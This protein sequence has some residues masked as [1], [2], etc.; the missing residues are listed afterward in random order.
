MPAQTLIEVDAH[1]SDRNP[2]AVK[3]LTSL[4]SVIPLACLGA[5]R[6]LEAVP[7]PRSKYTTL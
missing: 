2:L 5:S 7:R 3:T 6:E 4:G 1:L